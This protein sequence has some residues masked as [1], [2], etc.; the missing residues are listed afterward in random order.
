MKRAAIAIAVSALALP[1]TASA[2]TFTDPSGDNCG[3]F[4]PLTLCDDD[5][6]SVSQDSPSPGT[7]RLAFTYA[8]PPRGTSYLPRVA[9]HTASPARAQPDFL[10][11][12]YHVGGGSYAW[13]VRRWQLSNGGQ[14]TGAVDAATTGNTVTLTFAAAAIGG[15]KQYRWWAAG[16]SV[17]EEPQDCP[18]QLPGGGFFTHV[19]GG[20]DGGPPPASGD[21]PPAGRT[22]QQLRGSLRSAAR[23]G[24]RRAAR[25][26]TLLS[27]GGILHP[28]LAPRPRQGRRDAARRRAG[29]GEGPGHDRR[30]G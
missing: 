10:A 27:A 15:P 4:G 28:A 26:R 30:I 2:E 8:G 24:D 11:A 21:T 13:Q 25:V 14:I 9:I 18:E 5:A 20:G 23:T 19:L 6:T 1:A 3:V 29:A 7:I 17:A 16:G 12:Y 22:V